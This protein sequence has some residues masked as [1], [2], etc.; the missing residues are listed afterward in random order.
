MLTNL[1]MRPRSLNSTTPVTLANRVSSL[2]Q[3]TLAPGFSL[4]PRWRTMMLPPGTNW[5]PKTFTP[6]RCAFESRPFLELPRPF[7]CAIGYLHHHFAN[8]HF[9]VGLTVPDGFL[10]LFL[11]LELEDQDFGRA[12]GAD[13]GARHFAAGNQ[14]AA[15]FERCLD[16]KLYF[17]ADVAGQFFDTDHITGCYPILLSACLDDRVH[18]NLR[19]GAGT[20]GVRRNHWSKEP[21]YY[22]GAD[23]SNRVRQAGRVIICQ[24]SQCLRCLRWRCPPRPCSNPWPT[25]IRAPAAMPTWCRRQST[26]PMSASWNKKTDGRTSARPTITWAGRHSP[27]CS[28]ANRMRPAGAP[29]RCRACLRTSTARAASPDTLP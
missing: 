20:H 19:L 29:P 2:P 7:L 15:F 4:V 25:C 8:L 26:G 17:G 28:P 18:A 13:D 1:P 6:N 21:V 16:G 23:G 5:P 22:I 3:P 24:D 10:V 27:L 11:A 12:V 14:F 9:R